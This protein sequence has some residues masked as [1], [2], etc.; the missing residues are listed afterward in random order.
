MNFC[1]QIVDVDNATVQMLG[2]K[3]E[4][5]LPKAEPGS[6]SKLEV[7]RKIEKVETNK[8]EES[9]IEENSDS[10]V[11]LDDLEMLTS[12]KVSEVK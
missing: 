5:T 12:R 8:N 11:D 4:I 6:W 9:K 1:F 7:A 3:V 10:D 2:T